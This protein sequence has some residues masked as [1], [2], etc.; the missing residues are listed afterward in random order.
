MAFPCNNFGRQEP[1]TNE[2]IQNF[3]KGRGSTFKVMGKLE[4]DNHAKTHP[5]YQFLMASVSGGLVGRGLKWNFAKFLVN[6]EGIPIQ[7]YLP[8]TRPLAIEAD[9]AKLI[10]KS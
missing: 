10:E 2:Q 6:K 3:A 4:C 9:I 7:R 1:G 8:T 5:L